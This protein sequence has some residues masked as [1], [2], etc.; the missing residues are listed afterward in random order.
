MKIQNPLQYY[1]DKIAKGETYSLA[2]YGDGE[3]LCL[4]GKK[5]GNSNGCKYT[6]ELKDGLW[7]SLSW[8]EDPHFIYGLQ[9]VLP[10]DEIETINQWKEI[11][12]HDS[13]VFGEAAA[14][15]ELDNFMAEVN[16]HPVTVIGNYSIRDATLKLFPNRW[17]IEIPPM[18]ALTDKLRVIDSILWE[19]R[20]SKEP[21]VYL[22]S[23]GMAAN[24]MVSELHGRVKGWLLDV[25]HIWDPFA[26]SRSRCDL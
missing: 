7:N 19:D 14:K 13:E 26:G 21:K 12:W 2:R 8:Y 18:N 17:F 5:G 9:R 10:H 23:A 22:F 15:G 20:F 3:L 6:P 4:W 1:V 25:G 11:T 24:V 16:K